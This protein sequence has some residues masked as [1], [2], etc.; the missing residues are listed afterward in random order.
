MNETAI[1]SFCLFEITSAYAN[2]SS[3]TKVVFGT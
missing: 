2:V 1:P 3:V